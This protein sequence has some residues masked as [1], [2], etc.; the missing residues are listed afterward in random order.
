MRSFTARLR[1]RDHFIQKLEDEPGI[2]FHPFVRAL[3][4]MR[5]TDPERLNAWATGQTG[6]P[7]VDACVRSLRATGWLNFRMRAMLASFAAY[8][9]W[10]DWQV[11]AQVTAQLWVDYEPGI[12]YPQF[13]MQAGTTGINALRIYNPVKQGQDQDP[14]G[15]FVRRWIPQLAGVPDEFVH[16]PWGMPTSV[17]RAR[18]CRIGT[19]Y[20]VPIVD[21]ER[22]AKEARARMREWIRRPA[23]WEEANE[24]QRRHGSRRG[25]SPPPRPKPD[26]QLDLDLD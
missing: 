25:Q 11:P 8:Q 2:E 7:M 22:A 18:G 14:S 12:H 10:L 17:Q 23:V 26:P 1:W 21:P 5:D 24:V 4:G 6:V 13:Q 9:L 19:D 16:A 20:P 3:E 15:E